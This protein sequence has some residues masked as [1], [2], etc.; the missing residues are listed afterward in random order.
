MATITFATFGKFCTFQSMAEGI[1][2]NARDDNEHDKQETLHKLITTL[3]QQHTDGPVKDFPWTAELPVLL[4]QA[5]YDV[6]DNC[7]DNAHDVADT[8]EDAEEAGENPDDFL[9]EGD[10]VINPVN[11]DAKADSARNR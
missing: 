3:E 8:P 1:W 6:I 10:V 11:P 5:A 4:L 2:T 9:F 7:Y